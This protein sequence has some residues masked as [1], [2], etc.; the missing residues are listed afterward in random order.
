MKQTTVF[1]LILIAIPV[2]NLIL[3]LTPVFGLILIHYDYY[4]HYY[5]PFLTESAMLRGRHIQV[6]RQRRYVWDE[7]VFKSLKIN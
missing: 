5:E 4:C 7:F 1:V 6:N 2:F 3:I